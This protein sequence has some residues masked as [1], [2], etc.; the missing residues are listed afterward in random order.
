LAKVPPPP[1]GRPP[2]AQ[3]R[4][5]EEN[6]DPCQLD[7]PSCWAPGQS[8]SQAPPT[9]AKAPP[10]GFEKWEPP[11]ATSSSVPPQP[12]TQSFRLDA[13]DE[14]EPEVVSGEGQLGKDP[15]QTRDPWL[16]QALSRGHPAGAAAPPPNPQQPQHPDH[17]LQPPLPRLVQQ[18][19]PDPPVLHHNNQAPRLEPPPM[20]LGV[21][22]ALPP[23]R[24]FDPW[25]PTHPPGDPSWF[26]WKEHLGMWY[27]LLCSAYADDNHL[28][29][30][31]HQNRSR[32]P[33]CYL[34]QQPYAGAS[35]LVG[36]QPLQAL[37]DI[38]QGASVASGGLGASPCGYP[39]QPQQQPPQPQPPPSAPPWSTVIP[40]P[41]GQ[42]PPPNCPPP[43]AT[44]MTSALPTAMGQ[45]PPPSCPPQCATSMSAGSAAGPS[46]PSV[47][48][49]APPVVPADW[50]SLWNR[51]LQKYYFWQPATDIVQWDH[52][53]A[54]QEQHVQGPRAPPAQQA[55][56]PPGW[57]ETR[58]TNQKPYYYLV[59]D[60]KI[61]KNQWNRP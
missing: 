23:S 48:P 41:S 7:A 22:R 42:P 40:A 9:K 57:K 19:T 29:S 32:Y 38:S 44:T 6:F 36:G 35:A 28:A 14:S 16:Q 47:A 30:T 46:A 4:P 12:G 10:K 49:A 3:R 61:V 20:A 15:L 51:D 1:S 59:E 52:P 34:P 53:G 13:D 18:H 60:G 24:P 5:K 37:T 58:D 2:A 8:M 25:S 45:S 55:P 11:K 43:W 31:R 21:M 54:S 17:G 39:S 26:Q 33:E 50:R 56:L 27:C